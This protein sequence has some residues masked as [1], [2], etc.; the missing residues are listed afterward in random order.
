MKF[1]SFEIALSQGVSVETVNVPDSR[2]FSLVRDIAM[3]FFLSYLRRLAP[4][5]WPSNFVLFIHSNKF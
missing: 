1:C 3:L 2:V 4:F 5:M